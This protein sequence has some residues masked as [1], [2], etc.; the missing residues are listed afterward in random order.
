MGLSAP[1]ADR[2]YSFSRDLAVR[3]NELRNV[4]GAGIGPSVGTAIMPYTR[5]RGYPRENQTDK[6]KKPHVIIYTTSS[7]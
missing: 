5:L 3:P 1:M 2:P 4:C 6:Y 7:V